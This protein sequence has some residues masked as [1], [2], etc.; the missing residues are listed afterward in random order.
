MGSTRRANHDE[1]DIRVLKNGVQSSMDPDRN[2][3]PSLQL[4]AGRGRIP[5]EDCDEREK[6]RERKDEWDVEGE[7]GETNAEHAG[8]DGLGRHVGCH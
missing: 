3:E 5:L 7:T 8:P 4:S 2:A 1:V 6:V